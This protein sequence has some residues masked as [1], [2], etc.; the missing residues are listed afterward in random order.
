MNRIRDLRETM[1]WTQAQLGKKIGAARNTVSGYET[2]DR[3]LT[4][5]LICALCD[6][7][8]CTADYLLCRS[9]VP[10]PTV[11]P[12]QAAFLRAYDQLPPPIR[13]AV[14]D[15]IAPYLSENKKETA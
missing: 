8:G 15:L 4:P 13:R 2:E 5:A 10:W 11:T 9:D 14:D 12:E 7:F 1:G 3:Q 6:I